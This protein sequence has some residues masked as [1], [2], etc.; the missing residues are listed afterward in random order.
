VVAARQATSAAGLSSRA[1]PKPPADSAPLRAAERG[2]RTDSLRRTGALIYRRTG[3]LRAV[4][5]LGHAK[6][7]SAVRNVGNDL[8]VASSAL[9]DLL[10][11]LRPMCALGGFC[12][13]GT[14]FSVRF[15]ARSS[16]SVKGRFPPF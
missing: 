4:Q 9:R 1:A 3:N 8:I 7:E 11:P 14:G 12:A 10:V 16:L 2:S 6:L 5:L 15:P 13:Y